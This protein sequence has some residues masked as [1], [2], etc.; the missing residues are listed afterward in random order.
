MAI[1]VL[2]TETNGFPGVKKTSVI[3]V[4][5]VVL[6][7]YGEEIGSFGCLV[8]PTHP[9]GA[10]CRRAME[11]NQIDPRHLDGA[12]AP[13]QAWT[14]FLS[15]LSLHKPVTAVLAFNVSFD[16]KAMAK[17][18]PDAAHLPWGS[19]LMRDANFALYGNRKS[20]KLEVA[21]RAFGIP[22]P[23]D[24][25]RALWDARLAGQVYRAMQN[26]HV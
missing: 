14:A 26:A 3:E 1:C 20:V 12:P 24:T 6:T 15:W 22:I 2:D 13:D 18:F 16:Q 8:R 4:G 19:C 7:D 23:E 10:W 21:A 11:V 17:T 25:H 5:A 9:L